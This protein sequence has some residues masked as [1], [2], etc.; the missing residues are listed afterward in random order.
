MTKSCY[1]D[2]DSVEVF[3]FND[4]INRAINLGSGGEVEIIRP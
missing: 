1:S 2:G 3:D 4:A